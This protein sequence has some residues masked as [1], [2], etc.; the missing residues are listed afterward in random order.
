MTLL[1]TA[2]AAAG[3]LLAVLNATGKLDE[4]VVTHAE[5]ATVMAEHGRTPH[6]AAEQEMAE[7]RRESRC[8]SIN[9]QI[10]IVEQAIWDLEQN[11]PN[12]S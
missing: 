7:I 12:R 1:A 8:Q 4:M 11:N 6:A 9:I 5:L 2:G 10:V 3:A